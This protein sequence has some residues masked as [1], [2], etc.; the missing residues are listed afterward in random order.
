MKRP[1]ITL[2]LILVT[3]LAIFAYRDSQIPRAT[4]TVQVHPSMIPTSYSENEYEF[5]VS[6]ETLAAAADLLGIEKSQQPA[7][8]KLM[9]ENVTT[10]AVR[11]TDF[12]TITAKYP[13]PQQAINT[14]NAI[15]E[16]Y[17]Q[18][19]A[20]SENRRA[21]R[22]I[23]ALDEELLFQQEKVT[24]HQTDLQILIEANGHPPFS[25]DDTVDL[26]LK[27]HHY[28]QA[29][30]TYE[31]ARGMLREMKIKQQEA[32]ALLKIPRQPVTIHERATLTP[33]PVPQSNP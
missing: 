11:G 27:Q 31:Q 17:V 24:D 13:D 33:S 32:R 5:I 1:L 2:A 30:E 8:I 10:S 14:A 22:A 21:Q 25:G 15:A 29:K 7:A 23:E 28:T 12:I 18:R 16:A 4:A 26:S 20:E 19:R 3:G 6:K 9:D